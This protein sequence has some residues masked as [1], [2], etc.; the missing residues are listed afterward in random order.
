MIQCRKQTY[1]KYLNRLYRHHSNDVIFQKYG[2]NV[3]IMT[4][5]T[6]NKSF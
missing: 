1:V 4:S 5:S 2:R 3:T 6:Q